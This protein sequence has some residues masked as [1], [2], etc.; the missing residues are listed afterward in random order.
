MAVDYVVWLKN[1]TGDRIAIVDDWRSLSFYHEVNSIGSVAFTVGAEAHFVDL[2]KPDSIIEIYRRD[3]IYDVDWYVEWEGVVRNYGWTLDAKGDEVFYIEGFKYMEFLARRTLGWYK[4]TTQAAK[5][6][7][8]ETVIKEYVNENLGPGA[9]V[10]AGRLLGGVM[11]GLT[12]QADTSRGDAWEGD[13][14]YKNLLVIL[15]EISA[16]TDIYF[17]IIGTGKVGAIQTFEFRV[18]E[19]FRG[20]D[21]S[22][23]S[24]NPATGLNGNGNAPVIFSPQFGNMRNV[25]Y[26]LNHTAEVTSILMLGRGEGSDRFTVEV[27]DATAAAKTPW[28]HR[29]ISRSQNQEEDITALQ[30]AGEAELANRSM[31]P[32]FTFDAIRAAGSVYRRDYW[33]GDLV[34]GRYRE[35]EYNLMVNSVKI[36]VN[37]QGEQMDFGF[38]EFI[39]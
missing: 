10:G 18:Y 12:I 8:A 37:E 26:E 15:Q 19:D 23:I 29:E 1:T 35:N 4:G 5:A 38:K 16:M 11:S 21:R 39:S 34:T 9:T 6:D 17:D 13:R 27:V 36:T 3:V 25:K 32:L 33:F 31:K 20:E 22:T 14:A 30:D 28:N 2:I 7:I 24:L